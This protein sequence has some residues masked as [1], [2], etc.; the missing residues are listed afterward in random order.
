MLLLRRLL[1]LWLL[2]FWLGGFTF[3]AGVVVPIGTDVLAS[4]V[5]QG[6]ITRQV[7]V[8]LNVACAA[9][10]VAWAWDIVAQPASPRAVQSL[11]RLL[12]LLL[13]A[14]LA[15][16]VWLYPQVDALFDPATPRV[17]D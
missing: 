16:L 7:A 13:A 8:W 4:S 3:Y 1:L 9:A 2:M 15:V 5:E 17:L 11:Q 12:W 6:R 10:L 14:L